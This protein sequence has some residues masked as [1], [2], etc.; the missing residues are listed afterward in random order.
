MICFNYLSFSQDFPGGVNPEKQESIKP[1]HPSL[2]AGF[3]FKG[4]NLMEDWGLELGGRVGGYINEYFSA[5]AGF[6]YLFTQTITYENFDYD[7]EPHLR[8]GYAGGE[9]E[10]HLSM[11]EYI[12]VSGILGAY[13]GQANEGTRSDV[14]IS[15]D[16]EG[17]W[18]YMLEP[19]ICLYI[20]IW[21]GFSAGLN[22]QYRRSFGV[23]FYGLNNDDLSGQILSLNI[24][25]I[26]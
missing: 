18:I 12:S 20:H 21:D 23:D 10:L 1:K 26:L 25:S 6:Y 8:L 16:I 15:H 7:T 9:A 11:N 14:D 19:G 3:S 2:Y 13:I 22:Y 4:A 17:N 24:Y 5:G